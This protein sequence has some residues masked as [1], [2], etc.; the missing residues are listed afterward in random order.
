VRHVDNGLGWILSR[1]FVEKAFSERAKKFGDQIVSDIK[2]M[3]IEKLKKTTWMESSVVML[4]IE[5]VHK[6]VQKIGYP[7]KVGQLITLERMALTC[8]QSPNIMDPLSLQQ[9]YSSVSISSTD[10]FN[11]A[12]AVNRF[13]VARE[14]S[15]LGKPVDRDE[16]GMSGEFSLRYCLLSIQH[17]VCLIPGDLPVSCVSFNLLLDADPGHQF[18]RSTHI[19]TRLGMRS[20]S[21]LESCS[22]PSLMFLSH[23]T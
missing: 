16:W 5:K 11:N 6:I 12:L 1:F 7:T 18:P 17:Y 21:Q 20:F 19:T 9:Y 2:D 22:S 4:A 8:L 23:H 13:Q 10:F 14:W 3:F 15:S